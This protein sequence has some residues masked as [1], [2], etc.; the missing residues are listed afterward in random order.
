MTVLLAICWYWDVLKKELRIVW[1]EFI[2]PYSTSGEISALMV[3][4]TRDTSELAFYP[5][6]WFINGCKSVNDWYLYVQ[7]AFLFSNE[8]ALWNL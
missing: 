7:I 6:L 2:L 1:S 4:Q 5:R 8:S 3:R